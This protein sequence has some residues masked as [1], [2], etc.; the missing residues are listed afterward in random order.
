MKYQKKKVKSEAKKRRSMKI[1][2]MKTKTK[3]KAT[4]FKMKTL[5]L[6]DWQ[7]SYRYSGWLDD[8]ERETDF[9]SFSILACAKMPTKVLM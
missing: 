4:Y 9:D 2:K 3:L 8:S 6:L 7:S 1:I 5:L